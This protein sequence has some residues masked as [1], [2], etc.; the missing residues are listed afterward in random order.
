MRQERKRGIKENSKGFGSC[1]EYLRSCMKVSS[2]M[3]SAEEGYRTE[4][5][6]MN[7]NM[8]INF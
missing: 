8:F 5:A 4:G 1:E 7:F 6:Y 2:D 3:H